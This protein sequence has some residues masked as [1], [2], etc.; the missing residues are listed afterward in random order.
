MTTNNNNLFA[1]T[2]QDLRHG[3]SAEEL[4]E[5]LSVLIAAVRET[6]KGGELIYKI[7]IKPANKG[8]IRTVI[9]EDEIN[10]KKP[11][12]DRESS[13]FFTTDDNCLVRNDPRQRELELKTIPGKLNSDGD[14]K[15]AAAA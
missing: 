12:F 8:Q 7:K 6:G 9:V 10:L 14:K 2:L 1:R 15:A 13:I 4:S 3:A 11:G 5:Q